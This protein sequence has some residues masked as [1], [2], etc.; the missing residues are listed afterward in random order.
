LPVGKAL[1]D[2]FKTA[3]IM[4]AVFFADGPSLAVR[5][6]NRARPISHY[7]PVSGHVKILAQGPNEGLLCVSRLFYLTCGER[8]AIFRG[9][10]I[11]VI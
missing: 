6:G 9:L 4:R 3:L 7:P 10:L 1:A 11:E 2:S 5:G 8:G